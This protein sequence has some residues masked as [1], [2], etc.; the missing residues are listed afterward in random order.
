M[1]VTIFKMIV[2]KYVIPLVN[3]KKGGNEKERLTKVA[4]KNRNIIGLNFVT[5]VH[6][7]GFRSLA[8]VD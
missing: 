5:P 1:A 2:G 7:R 8:L 6:P 4:K 3:K